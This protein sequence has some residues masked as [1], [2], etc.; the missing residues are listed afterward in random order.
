MNIN[1]NSDSDNPE[2]EVS[3]GDA[4]TFDGSSAEAA[5]ASFAMIL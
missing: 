4:R 5:P 3:E 1:N 2:V